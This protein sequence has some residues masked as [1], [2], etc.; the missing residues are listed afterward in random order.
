MT[1]ERGFENVWIGPRVAPLLS[2]MFLAKNLGRQSDVL[3][4]SEKRFNALYVAE[5]KDYQFHWREKKKKERKTIPAIREEQ[6]Q[7]PLSSEDFCFPLPRPA[8]TNTSKC[9]S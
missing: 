2:S 5:P 4:V 6:N 8:L 7:R 3:I 1:A 9:C